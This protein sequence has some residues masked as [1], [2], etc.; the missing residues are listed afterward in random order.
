MHHQINLNFLILKEMSKL[1][2]HEAIY[3]IKCRCLKL[4]QQGL[5]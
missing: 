3:E 4:K 2:D 1:D 5:F